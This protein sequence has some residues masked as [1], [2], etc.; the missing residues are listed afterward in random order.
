MS[1]GRIAYIAGDDVFLASPA[2]VKPPGWPPVKP[3]GTVMRNFWDVPAGH[4]YYAAI[5]GLRGAGAVSGFGDNTY[6]PDDTLKR[7]QFA[8]MIVEALSLTDLKGRPVDESMVAPF[9]DLGIDDP[10]SLYPHDYIAVIADAGVTLGKTATHFAPWDE[11]TRAQVV[12]MVVRAV[13]QQAPGFL[14]T[15]PAGYQSVLGEFAPTHGASLRIAQFNGL[16]ANLVGYGP[17]WD[18]WAPASRAECAQIIWNLFP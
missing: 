12:T 4:H 11:V 15:P 1:G 7:A 2:S 9:S 17:M 14:A 18:A 3:P 6:R 16:T 10:L 8:K 13:Q 5:M